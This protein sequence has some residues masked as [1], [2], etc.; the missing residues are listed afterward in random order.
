MNTP[1]ISVMSTQ[2]KSVTLL[3]NPS[4]Y[5]AGAPA[6]GLGLIA[7][8]LA[9]LIGS[10]GNIHFDGVLD[11]HM[12]ASAPL[13]FFLLEGILDWL[14]LGVMLLVLGRI[15]SR[16]AFRTV[17]VLGTQALARWPTL[18]MS[19]ILL[20]KAFQRFANDLVAQLHAGGV[21]KI[22]LADAFVFLVV[23]V[24]LF[25]LVCWMVALMYKAFSVSCNVKGAKAIGTF[26]GGLLLAE[27]ISKICVVLIFTHVVVPRTAAAESTPSAA[28]I[29]SAEQSTDLSAKGSGFVDLLAKKDYA[30]A[31]SQFDPA[32]KSAMPEATLRTVWEDLLKQAGP[33]QKQL[34]TRVEKQAG[35]DVVLVTCQFERKLLDIKVVYDSQKRVTGLWYLPGTP[36]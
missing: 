34:R 33:F 15:I 6:L 36:Q 23:L 1:N 27:I 28:K 32:M 3:F 20:P 12:G 29:Q 31:E 24:A 11:T 7:I 35:Y 25:V 17:D 21:P 26:I 9:S 2:N 19:L 16:T 5:I 10:L 22:S 8:L 30:A 13:W 18:L 14:C 4:V